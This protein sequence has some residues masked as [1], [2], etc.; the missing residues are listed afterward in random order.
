ME[1]EKKKNQCFTALFGN[2]TLSRW[3]NG[4]TEPTFTEVGCV[5]DISKVTFY[6]ANAEDVGGTLFKNVGIKA[7]FHTMSTTGRLKVKVKFTT[8]QA[9]KAQRGNRCITLLFL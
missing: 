2:V 4:D 6:P 7:D 5:A 9:A 8:E 1:S 3:L